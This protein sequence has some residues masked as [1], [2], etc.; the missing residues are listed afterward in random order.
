MAK[1]S[2]DSTSSRGKVHHSRSEAVEPRCDLTAQHQDDILPSH[3]CAA[4]PVSCLSAV[5][6]FQTT[7]NS[8]KSAS[9]QSYSQCL[10]ELWGCEYVCV[11]LGGE[12]LRREWNPPSPWGCWYTS[13]GARNFMHFSPCQVRTHSAMAPQAAGRPER[14]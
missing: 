3:T 2:A 5:F 8:S 9:R 14:D 6:S 11:W 4:P 12:T 13:R 10:A 7:T 1:A